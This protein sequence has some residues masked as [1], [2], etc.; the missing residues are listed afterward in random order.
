MAKPNA[1]SRYRELLRRI[2][3]RAN[4][5]NIVMYHIIRQSSIKILCKKNNSRSR[6]NCTDHADLL[7]EGNGQMIP[8]P[9]NIRL[10]QDDRAVPVAH[11]H[12]VADLRQIKFCRHEIPDAKCHLLV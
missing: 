5:A 7:H 12:E 11:V 9:R 2:H 3:T 6:K 8:H 10:Q 4:I 1:Q